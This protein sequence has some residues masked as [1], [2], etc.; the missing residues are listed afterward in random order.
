MQKQNFGY[1][2]KQSAVAS[3]SIISPPAESG[4]EI[5][6]FS[7]NTAQSPCLSCGSTRINVVQMP[8]DCHFAAIRCGKCDTFLKWQA[9]PQNIE[10]RKR[11]QTVISQ[12]LKSSQLSEWESS[13]LQGLKGKKI[14]P[15]QQKILAQIESRLGGV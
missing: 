5:Q 9:K 3:S 2:T 6:E 10:I 13:F 4:Q 11:Q 7:A 8:S 14:S 12:L 1:S 15:R